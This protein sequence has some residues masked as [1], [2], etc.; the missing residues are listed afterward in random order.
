MADVPLENYI[1]IDG[2]TA[3]ISGKVVN[4][5]ALAHIYLEDPKDKRKVLS[6]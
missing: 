2:I 4:S 6:R 1:P 3:E 5:G